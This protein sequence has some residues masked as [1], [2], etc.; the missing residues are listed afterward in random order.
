MKKFFSKS[1]RWAIVYS[2]MLT[3]STAL[4]LLDAFVIPQAIPPVSGPGY[5]LNGDATQPTPSPAAAVTAGATV[6]MAATTSSATSP[7]AAGS[8]GSGGGSDSGSQPGGTALLTTDS[9]KDGNIS[10][11]IS[12][13]R[14]Y[15]TQVYIADIQLKSPE[16]LKSAFA[17]NTFG[18]NITQTTSAIAA[19]NGAIFAIN[20]DYCGFRN[21][22]FVIREGVLYR[23]TPRSKTDD[24]ALVIYG[25]GSFEVVRENAVSA[26]AL[27]AKGAVQVFS[28]G[29]SLLAGGEVSVTENSEVARA[30][31]SNPRTAM[32]IVSPM[33]YIFIVSDG[34]SGASRGLTL[35]EL[36]SIFKDKGCGVAY[37]LD[38]G[39][40]ATM[41]FNGRV[42]NV[43]TDGMKAGERKISD[44]VYIGY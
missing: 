15:G 17:N 7:A 33:H 16:Y 5:V 29:P 23:S 44:I 24:E 6:T 3:A 21:S 38:G 19:A 26:S 36:A 39:G 11:V 13:E 43:P 41:W 27:L 10:I 37:N 14:L 2:V 20:G 12:K 22:G 18:R 4:V 1:F 35:S 40:S 30:A 8:P 34:R 9:Y 25:D 42:V 31:A 28:F 32:G